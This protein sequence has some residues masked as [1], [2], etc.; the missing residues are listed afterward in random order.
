MWHG[1]NEHKEAAMSLLVTSAAGANGD[2][3]GALQASDSDGRFLG[4]SN[5]S[6]IADPCGLAVSPG[7]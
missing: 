4:F 5:D 2:G 1:R 6:R 3:F 7:E